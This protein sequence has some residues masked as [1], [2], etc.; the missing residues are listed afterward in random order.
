MRKY[1]LTFNF[2]FYFYVFLLFLSISTFISKVVGF[3]FFLVLLFVCFVLVFF[4][5]SVFWI[6]LQAEKQTLEK[7][8]L[9]VD[10]ASRPNYNI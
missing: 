9:P 8:R 7:C 6:E 3:F 5:L 10:V 2:F 4:T 1:F